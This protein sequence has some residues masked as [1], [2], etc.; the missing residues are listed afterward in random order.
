MQKE[1]K[2]Y[3]YKAFVKKVYD[4]DTIT[5]NI[6]LGF[7]TI[8]QDQKIR[9]SYINAPEIRGEERPDGLVSRDKLR[10]WILNKT[11]IIK[12]KKDSKGKYGRWLGEIFPIEYLND[13]TM[14]SYNTKL[15]NEGYAVKY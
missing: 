6:D 11:V 8:L 3:T 4:G 2:M 15:I 7:H 5:V 13:N 10:E 1:K 12:T 9:L 14:E